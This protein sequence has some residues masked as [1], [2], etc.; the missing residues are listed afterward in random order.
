MVVLAVAITT[1]VGKALI[2]RQFVDMTRIKI[3]G[4]LAAFPKL[5]GGGKQHTFVETDTVRYVYQALES[6]YVLLITNKASNIMEDLETVRLLSKVVPEYCS[7]MDEHGVEQN[8]FELIFACD[9]VISLGYKE[10]VSL[11]QIKT[12]TE[13]DSHEEKL[14]Q[15][16]MQSKMREAKEEA[17]RRQEKIDRERAERA[18]SGIEPMGGIGSSS[19]SSM[20]S[21]SMSQSTNL[22]N[23]EDKSSSNIP[24]ETRA[25]LSA[26]AGSAKPGGGKGM[27]LGKGMKLGGGGGIAKASD[28]MSQLKVEDGLEEV[29]ARPVGA[30]AAIAQAQTGP[31]ESV[32]LAVE[33]KVSVRLNTDS[34]LEHMEV[35][36]TLQL[37]VSDPDCAHLRVLVQSGPGN[38]QFQTHPNINKQAFA[39]E[40]VLCLRDPSRPFPVGNQLGILRWRLQ[41]N[42]E[43]DTP[44]VVTCWPSEAGS[45]TIVNMEYD[46]RTQNTLTNVIIKIPIACGESPSVSQV[47]GRFRYDSRENCLEWSLDQI[48]QSNANG[49]LEFNVSAS[50]ASTFFPT[51]IE[52]VSSGPFCPIVVADVQS[53]ATGESVKYSSSMLV[54]TEE[55]AV[56]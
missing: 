23:L 20:G 35:K 17:A 2:S 48:D 21:G 40:S 8:A 3:E 53:L 44:L 10:N 22:F 36:G 9:E 32:H 11:H 49:S 25:S 30:A 24:S 1:K 42:D 29:S 7:S 19:M 43:N 37:K 51:I 54:S 41:S 47:D 52:F 28:L 31:T 34:M 50:D 13:M 39:E 33:E 55:Y 27:A 6:L 45:S 38:H 16:I 14:H 4:L 46:L 26:P 15:M 56:M 12:F 5:I 18:R